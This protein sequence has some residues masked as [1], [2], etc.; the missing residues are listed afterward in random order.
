MAHDPTTAPPNRPNKKVRKA[1]R[2]IDCHLLLSCPAKYATLILNTAGEIITWSNGARTLYGYTAEEILGN[3]LSILSTV[4]DNEENVPERW[5]RAVRIQG[6]AIW[7]A[8]R[9][10][11]DQSSFC[12]IIAMNPI[13]SLDGAFQGYAEISLDS[14]GTSWPVDLEVEQKL[15]E[16]EQHYR[17]MIEN[18]VDIVTVLD[19]A[20]NI[21]FESPAIQRI[22]GYRPDELLGRNVFEFIHPAEIE[23]VKRAFDEVLVTNE[24]SPAVEFRFRHQDGT[25]R[26]VES[27]ARNLLSNPGVAG[28]IVNS[29]DIT[30][31]RAAEAALRKQEAALKLSHERLRALS[32]RLLEA[33]DTERRR[34]SRELHDD[35][36]QTLAVL[37]V[38]MGKLR[39]ALSTSPLD[40]IER[41]FTA[42]QSRVVKLSETVRNLAYQLHPSILDDLGLAVA[43]RSYCEDFSR[44]EGIE[45]EFRRRNLDPRLSPQVASCVYRV[46]QEALRN[47][48]KHSGAKHA[49][50]TIVG[51]DRYVNLTVRDSGIG[52]EPRAVAARRSLG[53]TSMMERSRLLNGVFRVESQPGQGTVVKLRIPKEAPSK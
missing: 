3:P 28:I 44:R 46:A 22:L 30:D 15:Q 42:L 51:T 18:E 8:W 17:A 36:N 31:R 19:E 24:P 40:Q 52:F 26:A 50:V 48:A 35:L 32:G 12:A 7:N 2:S 34:L 21:K 41:E 10:R 13:R 43:L 1:N 47:V 39:T 25:Y 11:K 38:D 27:I 20:G 14:A 29:R 53:L 5:M 6:P 16:S 33:E 4:K 45:I 37:A 9:L 23:R 49:C